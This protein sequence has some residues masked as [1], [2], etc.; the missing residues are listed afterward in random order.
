MAGRDA[1][2]QVEDLLAFLE[3]PEDG[4]EQRAGLGDAAPVGTSRGQRGLGRV[5]GVPPHVR[6]RPA[7][8]IRVRLLRVPED[9]L[10]REDRVAVGPAGV[11]HG[12]AGRF[13]CR[14]AGG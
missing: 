3:S 14:F 11:S 6:L 13:E 7:H 9:P 2:G 10:C 1:G 5:G 12:G 8:R 4:V